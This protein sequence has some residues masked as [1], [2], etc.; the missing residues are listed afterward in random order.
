M[1][2]LNRYMTDNRAAIERYM[3]T[4]LDSLLTQNRGDTVTDENKA[5]YLQLRASVRA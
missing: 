4:N 3:M 5:A 1:S 2:D